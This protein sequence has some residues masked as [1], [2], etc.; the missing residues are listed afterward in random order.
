MSDL[1]RQ[2]AI[3]AGLS[4]GRCEW[5]G[6]EVWKDRG[7]WLQSGGYVWHIDCGDAN[8][9]LLDDADEMDQL[10]SGDVRG[11]DSG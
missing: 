5:C 7:G 10:N 9:S 8:R 11:G 6:G 4:A 1:S 3:D 2:E